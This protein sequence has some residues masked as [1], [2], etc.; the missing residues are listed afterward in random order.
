MSASIAAYGRLG[1][2][3][4]EIATRSGKPMSVATLAL[5]AG[6]D[7]GPPLWLGIVAFGR[8][9]EQLQRHA[10]GDPLSVSGRVQVR[11]WT[12]TSGAEHEQLQVI[13]DAIVSAR[14]V[15]L[16]GP[17]RPAAGRAHSDDGVPFDDDLTAIER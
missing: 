7:D 12:D 10:K 11:R 2:D 13:A 4:R 5:D 16:G 3:P 9:A 14:T 15:R 6:D 17:R 1:A 8:L